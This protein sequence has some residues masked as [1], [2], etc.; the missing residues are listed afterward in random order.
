MVL[1]EKEYRMKKIKF[2]VM[3]DTYTVGGALYKGDIVHVNKIYENSL[4]HEKIKVYD[5]MGKIWF[6]ESRFLKKL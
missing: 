5:D 4:N 2:K 3:E 1:S 6:V